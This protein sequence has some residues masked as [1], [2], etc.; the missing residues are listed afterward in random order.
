MSSN[1][2]IV[3]P[4]VHAKTTDTS[5]EALD[6]MAGERADPLATTAPVEEKRLT[7]TVP[8]ATPLR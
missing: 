6:D 7:C 3:L 4:A 2:L 5:V 1:L 8:E